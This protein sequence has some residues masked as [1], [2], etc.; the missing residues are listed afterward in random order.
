MH[1]LNRPEQA[2]EPRAVQRQWPAAPAITAAA[3]SIATVSPHPTRRVNANSHKLR[4]S[5]RLSDINR[6]SSVHVQIAGWRQLRGCG[7]AVVRTTW[8]WQRRSWAL[9]RDWGE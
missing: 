2:V 1:L 9:A 6:S 5:I 4:K 8:L 3:R 7:N